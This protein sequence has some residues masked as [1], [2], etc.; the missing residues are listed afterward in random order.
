M[1]WGR[2]HP[3]RS[4]AVSL[5]SA[6]RSTEAER[7]KGLITTSVAP[8]PRY[9]RNWRTTRWPAQSIGPTTLPSSKVRFGAHIPKT[10]VA[11][12]LCRN[13]A[14]ASSETNL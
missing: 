14:T 2:I 4:A 10:H 9:R 11:S 3:V 6:S 8:A 12:A 1:G 13:I 7:S 5:H